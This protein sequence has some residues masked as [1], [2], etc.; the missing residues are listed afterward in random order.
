MKLSNYSQGRD[1][2]FN[3]IRIIAALAVLVTH[4]FALAIGT[5]DA[6]PFRDS[7]GMTLGSVAVDVFFITSGF[8]VTASLL[9]RQSTIEFIWARA[10]RIF[11]AL[12]VML[13]LTVFV[14]GVVFTALPTLTYLSSPE[15]Y[16]YFG[17]CV[18]LISGVGYILPG[19]FDDN[20]Y[21][22]AVNG[23]LWTMP[24]EIRMYAI[25]A[26]SWLAL[27]VTSKFRLALFQRLIVV[28][29]FVFGVGVF[30]THFYA[31]SIRHH[32]AMLF[33]MFFLGASFYVLREKIL[34]S[35]WGFF[36]CMISLGLATFHEH[37]FFIVYVIVIAYVLFY[38]AYVPSGFI[39]KYN[40][41]G[42]YS[43]GIY[44]Y[45]FPV[46]QSVA[47]LMP[48]V[49]VLQ[50]VLVSAAATSLLAIFSWHLLEQ[51]ALRYKAHYVGHTR[52]LLESN[53][54]RGR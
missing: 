40:Q 53:L 9:N 1:N 4:S 5:A 20:P 37:V 50:M 7:L 22:H 44:I 15:I 2:N 13:F 38:L 46:Q 39:R 16:I 12:I 24:W 26:V 52:R 47:H 18:T 48:G 49:S 11:P 54:L 32:Q 27:R 33:F 41:L 25:L 14:L 21:K 23:S 8:L 34:L 51:R 31:T 17:K 42:D 36:F 43:Y 6:E 29:A 45:A 3:L 35:R 19:V 30:F 10:L 28:L